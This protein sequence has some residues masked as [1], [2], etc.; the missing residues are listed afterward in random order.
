M[1]VFK[2]WVSWFAASMVHTAGYSL[3]A[4]SL[5]MVLVVAYGPIQGS[6]NSGESLNY[7]SAMGSLRGVG[8]IIFSLSCAHATFH[9]A[10]SMKDRSLRE[11]FSIS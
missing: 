8:S 10:G 2:I 3:V 5:V 9:A 11:S 7:F 1:Y 4:V 6:A